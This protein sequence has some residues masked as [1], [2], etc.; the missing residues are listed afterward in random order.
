MLSLGLACSDLMP[1]DRAAVYNY[2]VRRDKQRD[3]PKALLELRYETLNKRRYD[4][5]AMIVQERKNIIRIE[6]SMRASPSSLSVCP[7]QAV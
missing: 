1:V 7:A 2:Y 3:I 6:N 4:R 5:K